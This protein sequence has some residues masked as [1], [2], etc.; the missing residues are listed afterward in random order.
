MSV[1]NPSILKSRVRG[2]G[3]YYFPIYFEGATPPHVHTIWLHSHGSS[4]RLPCRCFASASDASRSFFLTE[5]FTGGI[6]LD[7][8]STE[9][10][11]M[12]RWVMTKRAVKANQLRCI[13]TRK[14]I[15]F[16]KLKNI[17]L[18]S[19]LFAE[20]LWRLGYKKEK[21]HTAYQ[22]NRLLCRGKKNLPLG[23]FFYVLCGVLTHPT[24]VVGVFIVLVCVYSFSRNASLFLSGRQQKRNKIKRKGKDYAN[25]ETFLCFTNL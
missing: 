23:C 24:D 18:E 16:V 14:L 13:H 25:P 1:G 5:F 15:L 11:P 8:G 19:A 2:R 17:F 10:M 9:V 12:A 21:P 7:V 6:I 3:Y 20:Q 22:L 4:H